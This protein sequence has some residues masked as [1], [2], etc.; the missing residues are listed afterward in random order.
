MAKTKEDRQTSDDKIWKDVDTINK[1]AGK[2][3]KL[4]QE[5]QVLRRQSDEN[6]VASFI[7]ID[8]LRGELKKK[9][10]KELDL[11]Q[12]LKET[13]MVKTELQARLKNKIENEVR[14]QEENETLKI[15]FERSCKILGL[16]VI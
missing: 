15:A 16:Q 3:K 9:E 6:N 12:K 2:I 8:I 1:D 4:Q 11:Q 14:L 7:E 5:L 10:T 13:E